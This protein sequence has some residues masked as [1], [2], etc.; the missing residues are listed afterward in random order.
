[1][2]TAGTPL[3][4]RVLITPHQGSATAE[5]RL[6]MMKMAFDNL[7]AGVNPAKPRL[8]WTVAEAESLFAKGCPIGSN[9][10]SGRDPKQ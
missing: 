1:V 6:M 3:D 2:A 8:P 5:T 9:H 10:W 7:E 4:G